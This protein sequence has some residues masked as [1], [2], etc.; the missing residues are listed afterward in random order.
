MLLSAPRL[1]PVEDHRRPIPVEWENRVLR[2]AGKDTGIGGSAQHAHGFGHLHT[3]E[4]GNAQQK[5]KPLG[6]DS[7]ASNAQHTHPVRSTS[8]A[9]IV[10][11]PALNMPP[12]VAVRASITTRALSR[13]P[14]GTII[15]HIGSSIPAGWQIA[16]GTNGTLDLRGRYLRLRRNP[17]GADPRGSVEHSHDASHIH[18]WEDDLPRNA[19]GTSAGFYGDS[20]S[21]GAPDAAVTMATHNHSAREDNGFVGTTSIDSTPPPSFA[22]HFIVATKER[23]SFPRGAIIPLAGTDIPCGWAEWIHQSKMDIGDRFPVGDGVSHPLM[24]LYGFST[25]SHTLFQTHT[26][27]LLPDTLSAITLRAGT[28]PALSQSGHSH[29]VQVLETQNTA[30]ADNTPPFVA[31]RFAIRR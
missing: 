9:P 24:A 29:G 7:V 31:L 30:S 20:L 21:H 6:L 12:S 23:G 27:R 1:Q 18:T 17:L 25:H 5:S 15:A 8:Q 22:V 11:G 26:V 19:A 28:G 16:D 10:T 2:I 13:V 14:A 3:G 4:S